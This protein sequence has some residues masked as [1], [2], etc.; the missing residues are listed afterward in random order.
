MI[1]VLTDG[2]DQVDSLESVYNEFA[3]LN[4]DQHVRVNTILIGS[5]DQKDLVD[6]LARIAKDNRGTMKVVS[7]DAL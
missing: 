7:K 6:L 1:Y 2:F 4:K 5:P 3:T